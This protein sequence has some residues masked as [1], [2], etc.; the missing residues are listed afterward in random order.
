MIVLM[1]YYDYAHFK[2][3]IQR[4]REECEPFNADTIVAIARGGMTLAHALT[5]ALDLRNLQSIRAESYD[6]IHQRDHVGVSGQCDFSRSRRV[7]VV[8]DIVDSGKT[9]AALISMFQENHPDIEFKTLSLF[10]KPSA[11]IQ[12]DYSLHIASE[13]IDFFWERDFLKT[14][15]L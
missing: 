5:M 7:L 12:P 11:L 2:T 9:M 13:W 14:D 8:D 15:L 6:G 3:D 4:L 1:I 10:T